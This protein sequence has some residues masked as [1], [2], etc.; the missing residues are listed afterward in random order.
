MLVNAAESAGVMPEGA[1]GVCVCRDGGAHGP[2]CPSDSRYRRSE[3]MMPSIPFS[4]GVQ[5]QDCYTPKCSEPNAHT[6]THR[7]PNL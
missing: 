1:E 6:H 5:T 3:S 2:W 7:H 4:G